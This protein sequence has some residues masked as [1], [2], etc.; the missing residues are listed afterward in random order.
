MMER[1]ANEANILDPRLVWNTMPTG[2]KEC[3]FLLFYSLS[4]CKVTKR[5]WVP[6]VVAC[7]GDER[8]VFIYVTNPLAIP[9]QQL[10]DAASLC[11]HIYFLL[12]SVYIYSFIETK[13]PY[14]AFSTTVFWSPPTTSLSFAMKLPH[15]TRDTS[16][17]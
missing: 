16:T 10:Y 15:T 9:L 17:C 4:L 2:Q 11:F 14:A 8:R 1:N 12:S 3:S 7:H 13:E 6:E 5:N